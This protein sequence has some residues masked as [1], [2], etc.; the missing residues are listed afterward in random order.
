MSD[1]LADFFKQYDFE[2]L[3]KFLFDVFGKYRYVHTLSE[4]GLDCYLS[5]I[6]NVDSYHPDDNGRISFM[7]ETGDIYKSAFGGDVKGIRLY[8]MVDFKD[9]NK[10]INTFIKYQKLKAFL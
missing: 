10:F 2:R 5:N 7:L 9:T 4:S 6:R 8:N 3:D 1:Q